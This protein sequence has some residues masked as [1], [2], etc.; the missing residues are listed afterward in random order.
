MTAKL[1]S[2][3]VSDHDNDRP[4][5][6]VARP[7]RVRRDVL[8]IALGLLL[9]SLAVFHCSSSPPRL[10]PPVE[11]SPIVDSPDSAVTLLRPKAHATYP[12][13]VVAA[14]EVTASEAEVQD[15]GPAVA[16]PTT[17]PPPSESRAQHP[18]HN[19]SDEEIQRR[20]VEDLAGL[21]SMSVGVPHGGFLVNGVQLPEDPRWKLADHGNT[22]G[23]Q[24]TVDYL[25]RSLAEVYR[26][27][28]DSEPVYV[29]HISRKR[30]G[31]LSPHKSHQS[32]RD[33]D[34]G[35]FYR[36]RRARWY[37]R[38]TLQNL[39]WPRMWL[40][41]RSL[42]VDTDVYL[43]FLDRSLQRHLQNYAASIGEDRA[44]LSDIF[45][46]TG[47]TGLPLIRHEPGHATHFH[48]R[49]HNPVAQETAR[50]CYRTLVEKKIVPEPVHYIRYKAR[51][52]DSLIRIAKHFGTTVKMLKRVNRLRSNKIF[53]RKY[54]KIPRKGP[55]K[56][57]RKAGLPKRRLPPFDPQVEKASRADGSPVAGELLEQKVNK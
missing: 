47:P 50:R 19:L 44:W 24:E 42:I 32:G 48:V 12:E 45:R 18:L 40:F 15:A 49:F 20:V 3:S 35:F 38:G 46:G 7:F 8:F 28:P 56:V 21:G 33:V 5:T 53:A 14:R 11:S 52:G 37:E 27:H 17:S 36:G 34:V 30:G 51:R 2:D 39:D 23:T 41:V 22:W 6:S 1:N 9:A 13:Y 57:L 55:A 10:A 31:R 43:I 16:K 4:Q 25:S 54:Y 29:G 26:E